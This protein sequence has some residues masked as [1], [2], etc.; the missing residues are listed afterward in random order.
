MAEKEDV[1]L[2]LQAEIQFTD[3]LPISLYMLES[4]ERLWDF[5]LQSKILAVSRQQGKYRPQGIKG[6]VRTLETKHSWDELSYFSKV[7]KQ[8]SGLSECH[9]IQT[10]TQTGTCLCHLLLWIC[11]KRNFGQRAECCQ[12]DFP[13]S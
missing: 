12:G 13:L 6:N 11:N 9:R 4:R 10:L 2:Q 5:L 3:R 8:G 7:K 1:F